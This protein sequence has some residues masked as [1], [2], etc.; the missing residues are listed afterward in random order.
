MPAVKS[1]SG[2]KGNDSDTDS[3]SRKRLAK[4]GSAIDTRAAHQKD[5]VNRL[6]RAEGQIRGV[7]RMIENQEPCEK[8]AQQ[9]TAART[10]LDRAFFVMMA[11]TLESEIVECSDS[12]TRHER[13][14]DILRLLSKY[15]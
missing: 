1:A 7:L 4:G 14:G 8:I 15:G 5:V 2:V 13:M 11:C 6:R 9:L 12:D 10:A 3:G